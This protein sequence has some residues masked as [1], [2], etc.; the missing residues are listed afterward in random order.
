MNTA[1]MMDTRTGTVAI[2]DLAFGEP[3]PDEVVVA[4]KVVGLCRSDIE[5]LHGHLNA[6]LPVLDPI[7]PGH[8]WSGVVEAVGASVTSVSVGERVV[9]ECVIADNHWFGFTYHGAASQ[10]FVVPATLLHK[11]PDY[12]DYSQAAL[13]EPFTIA[14]NAIEASG[15]PKPG[16][17]VCVIGAG[18]IGLACVTIARALGCTVVVIEPA[19]RRA[20][21]AQKLGADEAVAS[22]ELARAALRGLGGTGDFDLVIEA[23][24]SASGVASTFELA[25]I[26]GRVVNIGIC[27]QPLISAPL[28]LIQARNLTV[29]GV[30]GSSGIWPTAISFLKDYD[31]D[32][33]PVVSATFPL[34]QIEAAID[35]TSQ[36]NTKVQLTVSQ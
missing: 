21:L 5:L 9:G 30:T 29:R 27:S 17:R 36:D 12:M 14:F 24:G 23:S 13:I 11:V 28:H 6:Q 8:E 16:E 26:G 35:A 34:E 25:R 15:R 7:V 18:M 32:L 31:I 10:R 22:P 3:A 20:E 2:D 33:S 1:A 19:P 4:S